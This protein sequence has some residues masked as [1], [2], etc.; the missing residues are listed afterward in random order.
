MI[1]S[2]YFGA[3]YSFSVVCPWC[4]ILAFVLSACSSEFY[5]SLL[6]DC[7]ALVC[8]TC[9]SCMCLNPGFSAPC[10]SIGSI[11]A[12][13][14][15]QE[16]VETCDDNFQCSYRHWAHRPAVIKPIEVNVISGKMKTA[17]I[18]AVW[19]NHEFGALISSNRIYSVHSELC[20]WGNYE[21]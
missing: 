19:N 20:Q 9:V 7:P 1:V 10:W 6:I 13:I 8:D 17:Y 18:C 14:T 15:N 2:A 3:S 12:Y 11:H 16:D 21:N 4:F 5:F